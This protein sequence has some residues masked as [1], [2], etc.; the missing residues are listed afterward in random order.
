MGLR[1]LGKRAAEIVL[2]RTGVAAAA[3][4]GSGGRTL[5]LAYHNIV[6]DGEPA[7]GDTSL[8]LPQRSCARQLD[9]LQRTHDVVPLSAVLEPPAR[10]GRPRAAITLDD[11]TSGALTAGVEELVARRLTATFFVA[12]AFVPGRPFWWDVVAPVTHEQREHALHVLRGSDP[13]VLDWAAEQ[14][15]PVREV[16]AHQCCGSEDQLAAAEKAGMTFGTHTWSHR[17]LA[18]LPPGELYDELARPLAWLRARFASVLPWLAYP[19]GLWSDATVTM[20]AEL[21]YQAALRVDGGWV[22][23]RDVEPGPARY[24]LPRLNVPAGLSLEG[25]SLRA[26]GLFSR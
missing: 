5:I 20:A 25:F 23:G 1:Q 9:M 17:N 8:H 21:G 3:L 18:A 14:G 12:P 11:A 22:S 4:R 19:Y 7:R 15:I 24:R 26:A 13:A 6:P 10:R 2:C 16:P